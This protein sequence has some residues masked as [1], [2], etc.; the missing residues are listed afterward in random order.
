MAVFRIPDE[1]LFPNPRLADPTGL[2][3]V[4][5]D[6][7]PQRIL[8]AYQM[9]IFPWFSKGQPILWWSPDPRMVLQL[10]E[11]HVPKSLKKRIRRNDFRVTLDT[12]FEQVIN[13]CATAPRPD[14]EGTWITKEMID[15]YIELHRLG[16]AHSAEAWLDNELVG[17]LYGVAV[18]GLFSGESMFSLESDASKVAF[19]RLMQQ[20][21]RWKF[22]LVD[23]QVYTG[24]LSRFGATELPRNR[25]LDQMET[26]LTITGRPGKWTFD[27]ALLC[28]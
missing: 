11:L 14:Q 25:Y 23:C 12:A 8:L 5:G 15:A 13:A 19:A 26:A 18:G 1:H 4:G 2:L 27:D 20:L 17:G 16:Y 6:L 22:P 3:G 24:H 28:K 7:N 10:D 21:Q 9:G